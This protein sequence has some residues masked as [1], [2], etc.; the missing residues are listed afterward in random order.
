MLAS[1]AKQRAYAAMDDAKT[2]RLVVCADA[3]AVGD[4]EIATLVCSEA[5]LD[6][7]AKAV[8]L[9]RKMARTFFGEK[10]TEV[11]PPPEGEGPFGLYVIAPVQE[12]GDGDL[13]DLS[14]EPA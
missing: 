3:P 14:E 8:G 13:E 11:A 2:F 5:D 6:A 12:L 10:L 9:V 4:Q 1:E 7:M